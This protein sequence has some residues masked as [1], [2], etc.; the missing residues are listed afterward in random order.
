MPQKKSTQI[1]KTDLVSVGLGQGQKEISPY[2]YSHTEYDI[3]GKVV[4]Q[5]TFHSSGLISEK[6][7]TEY[8]NAGRVIREIYYAEEE[9]PSEIVTYEYNG[10]G[11][12]TG[13][14][15]IYGDGSEDTTS[16]VYDEDNLLIERITKDEEGDVETRETFTYSGAKPVTYEVTDDEGTRLLYEEFEY[17]EKGHTILHVRDS[18]ETGEYF[19][20]QTEYNDAGQKIKEM[21]F[22]IDGRLVESTFFEMDEAGHTVHLV[23]ESGPHRRERKFNFD[24]RGND[25]GYEEINAQGD[26]TTKVEHQYD[27]ENNPVATT[28]FIN[29]GRHSMSQHYAL[30]YKYEW[31]K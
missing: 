26:N 23:V 14:K 17:D 22:D 21:I 5:S 8:D 27:M 4:M 15:K 3:E 20:L 13:S 11:K 7:V 6:N 12:I 31:Y 2:L 18:E 24:N 25:L 28:V 16:Y 29:S 10:S 19:K 1:F 30:D 9:E